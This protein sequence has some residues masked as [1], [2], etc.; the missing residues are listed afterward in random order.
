[1][2]YSVP[3]GPAREDPGREADRGTRRRVRRRHPG[4]PP[5]LVFMASTVDTRPGRERTPRE[6]QEHE[7]PLEQGAVRVLGR[8]HRP[9]DACD[10]H[11]SAGFGASGRTGVRAMQQHPQS[12]ERKYGPELLEQAAGE[13]NQEDRTASLTGMRHRILAIRDRRSAPW[14]T[15]STGIIDDESYDHVGFEEKIKLMPERWRPRR[16]ARARSPGSSGRRGSNT[17]TRA[18]RTSNTHPNASPAA[19]GSNASPPASGCVT[20]RP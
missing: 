10:G 13:I 18:S 7:I 20:G 16:A 8:G 19:T 12:P 6:P 4:P 14:A 17:R 11:P 5:V 15:S 1:M 2:N 9:G 3:H